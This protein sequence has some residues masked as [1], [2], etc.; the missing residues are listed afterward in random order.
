MN[1]LKTITRL[2]TFQLTRDE[3]LQFNYK[4]FIAGLIGT[5]IVGMGRYWDKPQAS[6]VQH[7]GLGSVIYIFILSYFIW[8]IVLPFRVEK[9]NPLTVLTFISLTSFPAIIYAIPVEKYFSIDIANTT[10]AWFLLIV[11]AWRFS[12]LIFF[13]SRYTRL[14]HTYIATA[15]LLPVCLIINVL[16]ALNLDRVVFD[17]MCGIVNP[18]SHDNAYVVLV[19]LS[20]ISLILLIPLL[21]VYGTCIY[22]QYKQRKGAI[23][24]SGG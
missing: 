4:H 19:V 13:L 11:A 2:L 10:N 21:I 12:L 7:L 15:T 23:D 9:W 17:S 3:M 22:W 6:L 16:T 24:S 1:T 8:V 5:W 14:G 18:S 20:V